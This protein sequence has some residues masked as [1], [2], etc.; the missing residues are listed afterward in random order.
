MTATRDE[1]DFG[2]PA[3]WQ[4]GAYLYAHGTPAE[5]VAR[6]R[7]I[8]QD[9]LSAAGEAARADR[10]R[11]LALM[12]NPLAVWGLDHYTPGTKTNPYAMD[13]ATA[14]RL[15]DEGKLSIAGAMAALGIEDPEAEMR[16]VL[17]R[18]RG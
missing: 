2:A 15:R 5:C 17:R 18:H 14:L 13:A 6:S 7:R 8:D 1:R 10:P 12:G 16:E 3:S 11:L 4:Q 9:I